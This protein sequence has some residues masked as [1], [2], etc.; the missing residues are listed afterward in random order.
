[1]STDK[2]II[3][4]IIS[5]SNTSLDDSLR[6]LISWIILFQNFAAELQIESEAEMEIIHFKDVLSRAGGANYGTGFRDNWGGATV[7]KN[8][9]ILV[10]VK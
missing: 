3:K 6:L 4:D 10:L 8:C 5:V 7:I 1:M 2:S 9:N